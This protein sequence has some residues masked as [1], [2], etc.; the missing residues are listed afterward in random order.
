MTVLLFRVLRYTTSAA[1]TMIQW[2]TWQTGCL[3]QLAPCCTVERHPKLQEF[4]KIDMNP[5]GIQ[6]RSQKHRS[7]D[8]NRKLQPVLANATPNT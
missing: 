6:A 8:S 7:L 3:T 4:S 5:R 1:A 2:T